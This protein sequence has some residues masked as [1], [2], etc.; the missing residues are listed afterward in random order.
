MR[1]L[2][3]ATAAIGIA[4][5][6]SGLYGVFYPA[7]MARV[8]GVI[9]VS[10]DMAVFYPGIG[11]RNFSAGLAVWA[12]KYTGQLKALGIFLLCWIWVGV[13]D[14]YL[15]LIHYDE[16]DTVW[17]HVFNIFS[18]KKAIHHNGVIGYVHMW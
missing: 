7:N 8:F 3:I 11:G 9:D 5:I 15:L 4:L 18:S 6:G 14:T 16:V 13:A 1:S 10:R 17:L 2:D 12:F